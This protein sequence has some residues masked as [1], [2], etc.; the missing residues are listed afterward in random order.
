MHL[1]VLFPNEGDVKMNMKL[2]VILSVLI[3]HL[4]LASLVIGDVRHE[5]NIPDILDYKT[6]K[7]DLH[8]HT[9]FSDGL[10]WPIVRVDEAWRQG[11]DAIS[12]TD[13]IEYQPHKKDVPNSHNRPYE[14]AVSQAKQKNILL[15]RGAEI[16]RD[17]PPGHFN[18]IFL[19][20]IEP[21]DT[22]E[23][24]D[25][26]KTGKKQ[27]AFLFWNH[28]G[29]KPKARGWFDIH[30]TLYEN[31][32]LHGIEVANGDSYYPD[33]HKWCLE[34]NLTMMGNSD[35]HEPFIECQASPENHRTMTLVFAKER[36]LDALKDALVNGR[37]A[38]WYKNQ[39]IG[40]TEYLDAIFKAAVKIAN[41]HHRQGNTVWFEIKNDSDID[42]ELVKAGANQ[43]DILLLPANTEILMKTGID[44]KKGQAKLSYIAKNF[45][46]E[47]D[48]GLPVDIT[49]SIK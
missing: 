4:L 29:W 38:V 8:M 35:A 16:T 47:P 40:R 22:K 5:I 37:T 34:K 42:I 27:N 41:P 7:C 18:A 31:K 43:K 13:H 32:L 21:L 39:L 33:G 44:R 24:L 14:I 11:L 3:L 9:V 49:V 1:N 45:L 46:V 2:R 17:T 48:K 30:T 10:V 12:I 36:T 25:A 15:I 23:L 19:D 6:L 20:D 28:P 26:M